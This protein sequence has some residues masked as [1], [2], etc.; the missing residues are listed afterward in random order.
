VSL[1]RRADIVREV[2]ERLELPELKA[3]AQEPMVSEAL[4]VSVLYHDGRAPASVA[5]LRRGH[6]DECPLQVVYD[7]LPRPASLE[8]TIPLD[9][10][11]EL[12]LKLRR[13]RFDKLDD[14]ENLP[15]F[16]VDLWLIERVAGSF[17]HDVVLCPV[18]ARGHHRELVL[19]LRELLPEAV[20]EGA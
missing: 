7:K 3:V 17:F 8:F 9:R 13:A 6:S 18:S 15:Y 10:Y 20:R 2:A 16:D 19:V 4:R 11:K 1:L 5:T 12:L 14:E